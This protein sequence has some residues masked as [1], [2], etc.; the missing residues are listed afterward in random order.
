ML[1]EEAE[2]HRRAEVS[3]EVAEVMLSGTLRR[4]KLPHARAAANELHR[5]APKQRHHRRWL[6]ISPA[7]AL[8]L[9]EHHEESR[10]MHARIAGFSEAQTQAASDLNRTSVFA[11]SDTSA[12]V[13]YI[14]QDDQVPLGDALLQGIRQ[15]IRQKHSPVNGGMAVTGLTSLSSQYV[16]PIGVGTVVAP[17]NCVVKNGQALSFVQDGE[18]KE[19]GCHLQDESQVWVVFDTGSTNIWVASDLCRHGA[20]VKKGRHRYDHMRS[21]TYEAPSSALE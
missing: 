10:S 21:A 12:K 17:S 3:N 18:A 7:Q 13:E 4:S 19:V 11:S 8:G 6:L 15:H 5:A 1:Q 20:C 2:W 14:V 16:G 9:F